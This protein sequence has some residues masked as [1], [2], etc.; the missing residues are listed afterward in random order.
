[1]LS[2]RATD[3]PPSGIRAIFNMAQKIPD[4]INLGLGEPDYSTPEHILRAATKAA[5]LGHTHYTVN[6]GLIELRNVI[7]Q[8]INERLGVEYDAANEVVATNGGMGG[9]YLA[10][11]CLVDPGDE[12]VLL[13]PYWPNYYSQVLLAGGVPVT[14][15]L[16][17]KSGFHATFEEIR[18]AVSRRT[19]LLIL[20]TPAN[21]TGAMVEEGTLQGVAKLANE[22]DFF[23][24][25]DEVYDRFVW[26]P[27]THHSIVGHD[28]ARSRTVLVNSFSKTYAMTGWRI[29]YAAGPKEI[30]AAMVKLQESVYAC[31]ASIAQ[32]AALEALTGDQRPA[33]EM[34]QDYER[35][36]TLILEGLS[37]IDGVDPIRPQGSFYVFADVS[38]TG[39]SSF[40]FAMRLLEEE[41]VAV[42]PGNAFGNGGEGFV[43]LSFAAGPEDL[44]RAVARIGRFVGRLAT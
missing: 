40:H 6:A 38:R 7:S 43:R 18:S 26:P 44:E 19:K 39:L 33:E 11:Q 29:G 36:R 37:A 15:K 42:V 1:M 3:A 16:D 12:V 27:N 20:N 35:R 14:V 4:H 8:V 24:V 31:P 21:P 13:E 34:R 30:V 41:H 28:G 23:V 2:R 9:L 25:S 5:E 10:I 17:A 32:H 22:R